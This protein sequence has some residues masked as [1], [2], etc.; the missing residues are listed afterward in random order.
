M[1]VLAT[2]LFFAATASLAQTPPVAR[3]A[4]DAK[5]IDRVAEVSKKDLPKDLLQ[6][7]LTEDIDLLRGKRNDGTYQ[8]AAYEK[9]EASRVTKSF[10][11]DPGKKETVLELQAPFAYRLVISAPS[12]RM[13]VTRNKRVYVDRV[14][15]EYIPQND[16]VKKFQTSRV[17]AWIEPGSSKTIELNDIA[18]QATVRVYTHADESGYGNLALALIQA[19]IFDDPTSPYADAVASLK[20]IVK[21][22]GSGDVPAI[23]A[24]AQRVSASL[25]LTDGA[26]VAAVPVRPAT[27]EVT[28]PRADSDL[29]AELQT[30]EDLLTGSE[31][32]RRQGLDR[33]HQLV[34]R[35]RTT[36]H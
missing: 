35:L 5:V 14:E 16:S 36:S 17:E 32:E 30:V 31:S 9:M 11:V 3:V 13:L 19:R 7:I 28:A 21:A 4:E 15:I 6:R 34:R 20:A 25:Q 10:S 23:R 27:V 12:R 29:L 33:L 22:V 18:R 24:M 1:K 26:Q 2:L 8:Y